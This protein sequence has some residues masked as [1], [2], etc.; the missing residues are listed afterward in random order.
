VRVTV[1]EEEVV[2]RPRDLVTS[3]SLPT[4]ITVRRVR[5]RRVTT[6]VT[7]MDESPAAGDGD[8]SLNPDDPAA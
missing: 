1:L 7:S 2:A 4:P 5:R 8:D 6:V 3:S